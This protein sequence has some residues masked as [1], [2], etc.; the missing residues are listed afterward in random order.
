MAVAPLFQGGMDATA[1]DRDIDAALAA[2]GLDAS[3]RLAARGRLDR[4]GY[5]RRPP[6]QLPPVVRS[7][8]IPSLMQHVLDQA[9]LP[10]MPGDPP[11]SR[12]GASLGD[13]LGSR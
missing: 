1:T 8:G 6:R 5:V 3:A 10:A 7:A 13:V 12:P 2:T 11:G 9:A 4:L